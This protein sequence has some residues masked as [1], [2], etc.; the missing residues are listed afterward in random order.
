M[1]MYSDL[2]AR[3][4]ANKIFDEVE[5]QIIKYI[6]K[7]RSNEQIADLLLITE[8]SVANQKRLIMKKAGVKKTNELLEWISTNVKISE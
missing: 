8:K 2:G 1:N 4:G 5:M 7:G 6:C 3:S